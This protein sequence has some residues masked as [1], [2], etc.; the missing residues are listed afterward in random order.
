MTETFGE[1]EE[2]SK[3]PPAKELK[4]VKFIRASC[5]ASLLV[6]KTITETKED[7]LVASLCEGPHRPAGFDKRLQRGSVIF[8]AVNIQHDVDC[9]GPHQSAAGVRDHQILLLRHHLGVGPRGNLHHHGG[10]AGAGRE[11][12]P[13]DECQV[14]LRPEQQPV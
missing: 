9:G 8:S 6:V 5:I 12:F 2:K 10:A 7:S 11:E 3:P 1:K 14:W 13:H 4:T